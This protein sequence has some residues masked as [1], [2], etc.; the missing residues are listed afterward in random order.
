MQISKFSLSLCVFALGGV[1]VVRAVDTPAQAAA[2]AALI[3]QMPESD[4]NAPAATTT[5][6]ATAAPAAT[7][8][9]AAAAATTAPG[10]K[11]IVAPPLP[12][13]GTKEQKLQQLLA[14]YKADQITAKQYHD[15]R[16]AI[17]AEK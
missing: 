10:A 6:P 14:R 1:V 11:P 17:L 4:T 9:A 12:I 15:Q 16:A 2:R 13:T 7:A 8:T 5:A 3:K